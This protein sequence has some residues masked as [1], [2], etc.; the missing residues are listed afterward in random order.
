MNALDL[1]TLNAAQREAVMH[2]QGPL[3]VFAGAGSGKTRVLTMRIARLVLDDGIWPSRILAVTFTNKAAREMRSRIGDLIGE[4]E[5]RRMWIGTFHAVCA[6]LL[7]EFHSQAAL[8]ANFTVQD[9]DDQVRLIKHILRDRNID[10]KKFAPRG[11]LNAISRAK[12][13]MI[14]PEA[15]H[16]TDYFTRVVAEIYPEYQSRLSAAGALDFDDLLMRMVLLLRNNEAVRQTLQSRFAHIL[17]DEYQDVNRAQYE[18]VQTLGAVHRNICVVGDDDQSI[19]SWR[20]ADVELI[21]SFERDHPDA[22]VVRLEQNYRSTTPILSVANHIVQKNRS[23]APKRLWTAKESG[24]QV[25]VCEV[26]DEREEALSIAQHILNARHQRQASLAEFALLYRTNAQSRVFEQVF[27]SMRVPYQL[28]GGQRF[29][30]RAEIKDALCYLRVASNPHDDLALLRII[31]T[32]ARGIGKTTIDMLQSIRQPGET[33]WAVLVSQ[34]GVGRI[35]AKTLRALRGFAELVKR[36]HEKARDPQ[37]S[38]TDVLDMVYQQSGMLDRM[39]AD[40]DDDGEARLEN[41]KELR[42]VTVQFDASEE[43]SGGLMGFLEQVALSS[44]VDSMDSEADR[45]TLMTVHAA[46]GLEFR[47]VFL[48]G[49]E[50]GLFPHQLSAAERGNDEE[51]RRLCYVAVTRAEE[52]LYLTHARNRMMYGKT[53]PCVPSR[54]LKDLPDAHVVAIPASVLSCS[55]PVT[56]HNRAYERDY[57]PA[58]TARC[59]ADMP[60]AGQLH[61]RPADT[62]TAPAAP[63]R[64]R[65]GMR[66]RHHKFGDGVIMQVEPTRDDATVTVVFPDQGIKRLM[67]S[68][69]RLE[70]VR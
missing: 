68:V 23:R 9:D 33:F 51:E 62:G 47:T 16:A 48:V 31:N 32:P 35:Q 21:L 63:S 37:A 12:E 28:V 36:L 45:V 20:G 4:T 61:P 55:E 1:S 24:Q 14:G 52:R 43:S 39:A 58:G 27:S 29:F 10:D 56:Q 59:R 41:L 49:M 2:G 40:R 70:Q 44:D 57:Q 19:Y 11:V 69:A 60:D 42:T 66:V 7:R 34:L 6:R 46:K 26:S 64:W 53:M 30:Q 15:F 38:V 67:A 65:V 8:P 22:R 3:L 17:V 50:E 25:A 5:A 54:F 18:M 13:K